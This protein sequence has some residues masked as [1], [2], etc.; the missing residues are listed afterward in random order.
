MPWAASTRP[1][2]RKLLEEV[3]PA[4]GLKVGRLGADLVGTRSDYGPFRDRR[5][6]FLFLSTGQHPDYHRPT[7]LP[8]R[9]DY[10]K[11]RRISLVDQRPDCW[12]LA[13]DDEAP[14]WDEQGLP[15]DLEEVHT[16]WLL[17]KRTLVRP[18]VCPLS[19]EQ[20]ERLSVVEK[21]LAGILDRGKLTGEERNWLVWTARLL[22][23]TVY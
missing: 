11:L 23:L 3:K 8:E 16:V 18:E 15:P 6:P 4:D 19:A 12:R 9:I 21:R 5:V 10:E 22:L 14:A 7:D 1:R 13:N 20:R 17:V 2:L